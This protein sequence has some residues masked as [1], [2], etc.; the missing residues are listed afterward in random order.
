MKPTLSPDGDWKEGEEFDYPDDNTSADCGGCDQHWQVH[1]HMKWIADG[2][3]TLKDVIAHVEAFAAH[4][5]ARKEAGYELADLVDNGH[6]I[7]KQ[8][9]DDPREEQFRVERSAS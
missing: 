3:A 1:D 6:I 5:W 4:L 7:Y 8:F 9:E 2:C